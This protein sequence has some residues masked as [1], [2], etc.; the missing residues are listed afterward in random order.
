[1][2]DEVIAA[3]IE[4]QS[5]MGGTDDGFRVEGENADNT[6]PPLLDALEPRSARRKADFQS[7]P[8]KPPPLGGGL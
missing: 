1:V 3:Y 5:E 6:Q 8:R 4:Q 7:A 2:T